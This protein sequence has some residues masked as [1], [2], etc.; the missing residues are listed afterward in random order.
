VDRLL[1][2]KYFGERWGR[3]WLDVVRF[4]ESSGGGRTLLFPDAWR[5][6]D[7]VIEAFNSDLPYDRFLR[8]QIA[9]DLLAAEDWETRRRQ[10]IA[11]AFLVLGPTNYELQDKEIL[12]M[13]IVDEQ[14]DT[15]GKALLGLTLG[16]ARC[17]DHKFDPIPTSDYYAMAGVL[18]STTTLQGE[19][20]EFVSDWTEVSLPTTPE[21]LEKVTKFE[22]DVR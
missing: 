1:E 16:C 5:Y 12:E 14:L 22:N 8:E 7:Y 15:M 9:G 21:H 4:A 6:R 2:S 3:H 19:I 10:L 13:D 18:C 20:Q 17:H 11:T